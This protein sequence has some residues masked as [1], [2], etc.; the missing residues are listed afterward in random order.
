MNIET[1]YDI[2]FDLADMPGIANVARAVDANGHE[3]AHVYFTDGSVLVA[4]EDINDDGTVGGTWSYYAD[5][6]GMTSGHEIGTDVRTTL[7][8]CRR[9]SCTE[10]SKPTPSKTRKDPPP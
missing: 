8:T 4:Q 2:A 9:R 3:H 5:A 7:Q 10:P 6:D 1:A